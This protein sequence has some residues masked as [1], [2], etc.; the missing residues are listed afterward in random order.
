MGDG[1]RGACEYFNVE[2]DIDI[3]VGTFSKSLGSIGGFISAKSSIA[4]YIRHKASAFIFTAAL[5]PASVAGVIEGLHILANDTERRNRLHENTAYIKRAF[6]DMGIQV[7]NSQVPIVPIQ[8]GDEA[9]TLY[10]NRLLFDDGIFAGVAVSP[11][12]PPL[13]AMIRTSYTCA[14]TKEDLGQILASFKKN[15]QKLGILPQ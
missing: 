11:V 9:L 1:G 15:L 5:P 6:F 8:V 3:Y 10:M 7:N 13:K 4:E 14:H 12:V 2:K